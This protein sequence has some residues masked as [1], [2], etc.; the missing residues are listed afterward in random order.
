MHT[1]VTIFST[2]GVALTSRIG[3]NGV[4]RTKVASHAADFVLK[5]LVVETGF[6]FTLT[7]GRAGD[8]HGGLTTAENYKVFLGRDGGGVEGGVGG[9]GLEDFKVLSGDEL[10]L[11][12]VRGKKQIYVCACDIYI[13]IY[14]E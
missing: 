10:S 6:E 13:Y 14:M 5:D 11:M 12:L 3:G 8:V 7:G 9:V 1:D 2:A 4:E